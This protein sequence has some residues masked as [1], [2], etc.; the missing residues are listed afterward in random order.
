MLTTL[1]I[2]GF[3]VVDQAEV[4]LGPGL[5]VLTGETGTGKS[6]LINALHLVLGGRMGGEVLREGADEAVVEALFE[7]P[8]GH[9]ALGRVAAAG[10]PVPEPGVEGAV[11]L[12]V[13][14]VVPRS[15]RGR[16]FVNG[17]LCTVAILEAV[18]RGVVDITGQHEHVSL[19]DGGTHLP[20]LDAFAGVAGPGGLGE[21]YRAAFDSL[22]AAVREERALAR[23]EGE[24][25]RRADYL[26]FQLR[27]LDEADPQPGEELALERERRVLAH[28]L[29]LAKAAR[30][31][32]ALLSGE[33]GSAVEGMG[34]A[35]R[36]LAEAAT[37]DPRLESSLALLRSAAAEAEEA[38]RQLGRYA[39]G[40]E[41]D[42]E[43]LEVLDDRLHEL[44]AL[45]R[46]HGGTLDQALAHREE[47]RLE[48]ARLEGSGERR[49][50]LA[51]EVATRLAEAVRLAEELTRGRE[52]GAR[53]FCRA[54]AANLATLAMAR[55]RVEV[56]FRPAEG[57]LEEGGHRLGPSGAETAEMLIAPNPGEP[58]R[59]LAKVASG[60]ELSRVLLAVKRALSR[61]DPVSCYVFDEVDAGIGGAVAEAVGRA[62]AEVARDRQVLC[63]T[64]LPQVAVFASRHCRVEKKVA[65]GR[66]ATTV[67][68]L[69]GADERRSEV[70]RMLAGHIVTPSALEHARALFAAARGGDDHSEPA[71]PRGAA[72]RPAPRGAAAA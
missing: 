2:S 48:L 3:A 61:A 29:R 11:E 37:L 59:P 4:R 33:E 43:R 12:L 28:S 30:A 66:T 53:A 20:L 56:N 52:K 41:G 14:R 5:N 49:A 27:E 38:G 42:P 51:G 22:S 55:C 6:L 46:K 18:M 64:H 39:A 71:R 1:R 67:V 34:R 72:A 32:E 54:V 68:S 10:L 57:A 7:L 50:G 13:R 36:A 44:K 19:L 16:V 58:P 40:L 23:D 8:I 35:S 17:A 47:M 9:P 70:A 15:G 65:A 24:R 60:G 69:E 21:R 25:S 63:V 31:A 45:A 62:L 26:A